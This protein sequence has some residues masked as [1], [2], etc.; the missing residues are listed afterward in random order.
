MRCSAV[1]YPVVDLRTDRSD[2][3]VNATDVSD[4]LDRAG[5]LLA[6]RHERRRLNH[7]GPL[8]SIVDVYVSP[9]DRR[10][11]HTSASPFDLSHLTYN[12]R[13]CL[14]LIPGDV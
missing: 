2:C 12:E 10:G 14:I 13:F 9:Y 1:S 3:H 8:V 6:Q 4:D 7:C 5:S 11:T